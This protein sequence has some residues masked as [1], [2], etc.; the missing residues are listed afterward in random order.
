[1]RVDEANRL[2]QDRPARQLVKGS[3]WLLLRNRENVTREAD[4]VRLDE[5]L[6]ANRALFTVYVLKDDL[7]TL[8]NYRHSGYAQRFWEQWYRRAMRSRMEP[9]KAFARRVS[10]NSVKNLFAC[11]NGPGRRCCSAIASDIRATELRQSLTPVKRS[12]ARWR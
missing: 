5:L 11:A 3:R 10:R 6:A 8:W 12:W 9:L 1:M 4:Q 7:K 2:R